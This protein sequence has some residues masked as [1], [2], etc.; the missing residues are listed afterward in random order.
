[1]FTRENSLRDRKS[2]YKKER[3]ASE[4]CSTG[5]NF[6]VC[7]NN[8]NTVALIISSESRYENNTA[9]QYLKSKGGYVDVG[10]AGP[11]STITLM[12]G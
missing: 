11:F 4:S 3:G 12:R 9:K 2:F 6:V 1:M 10:K 8:D 7:W 5:H